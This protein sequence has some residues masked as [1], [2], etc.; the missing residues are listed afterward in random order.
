MSII[1]HIQYLVTRHDCVVMAGLGALV[2]QREPA[3]FSADGRMLLPPRR[4]LVF[5]NAL[6]HDDGLLAGSVA[7]RNGISFQSARAEV[8]RQIE[9]LRSRMAAEG[10]VQLPRIGS[11]SLSAEGLI[12]F[13][14]EAVAP[15]VNAFYSALPSL[16][17]STADAAADDADTFEPTILEVDT[18]L[19]R[20]IAAKLL[21]AGKY[22]AVVAMIFAAGAALTTPVLLDR[23]ADRAALSLPAVTPAKKATLPA[24]LTVAM[25]PQANFGPEAKEPSENSESSESSESSELSDNSTPSAPKGLVKVSD[26]KGSD[27]ADSFRCFVIVGSCN[28]EAEARRFIARKGSDTDLRILNAD[29]RF[30]IYSAMSNNPEAAN[31]FKSTDPTIR[32]QFPDAW[33]YSR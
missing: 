16:R 6:T 11:L 28:T 19:G 15:I 30:R 17:L 24:A 26:Y 14:P 3:K 31:T 33:V 18:T 32:A 10:S 2:A 12:D 23:P 7:R 8:T 4:S 27:P 21:K 13:K 5:N 1:E 20:R 9:L 25:Q 22:A 29:G